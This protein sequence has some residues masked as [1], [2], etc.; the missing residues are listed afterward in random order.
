MSDEAFGS[1]EIAAGSGPPV[2]LYRMKLLGLFKTDHP[3]YGAGAQFK[4]EVVSPPDHVGKIA[5]RTGK[6]T[7]TASN[8]TGKFLVAL[9]GRPLAVGERVSLTECIG[10]AY[11][12]SVEQSPKGTGTRISA[13][14]PDSPAV[15]PAAPVPVQAA[16]PVPAQ[17]PAPAPVQAPAPGGVTPF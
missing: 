4:M 5:T 9:L 8:V 15:V 11:L 7:P 1:M 17:V 12:V 2:G 10:R 14:H 13:I 16:V 6:A 3:E